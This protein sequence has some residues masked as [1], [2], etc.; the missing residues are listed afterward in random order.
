MRARRA[1]RE[2]LTESRKSF[3]AELRYVTLYFPCKTVSHPSVNCWRLRLLKRVAIT[4]QLIKPSNR[5]LRPNQ[6]KE[7]FLCQN[8][9]SYQM[10]ECI[11]LKEKHSVGKEVHVTVLEKLYQCGQCT[12]WVSCISLLSGNM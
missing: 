5:G 3:T 1:L 6:V 12:S 4:Q 7:R 2:H 8:V 11:L 10:L 9:K